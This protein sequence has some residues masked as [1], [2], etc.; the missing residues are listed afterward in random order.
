MIGCA[1]CPAT[2]QGPPDAIHED[3]LFMI[4]LANQW[5]ILNRMNMRTGGPLTETL[6]PKCCDARRLAKTAETG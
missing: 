4:C 1:R 3:A 5:G 2:L 6:C